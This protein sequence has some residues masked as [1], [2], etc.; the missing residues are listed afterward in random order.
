[1]VSTPVGSAPAEYS[2]TIPTTI[3]RR[4]PPDP[5]RG[6][7]ET[8]Y[9]PRPR[10]LVYAA[11]PKLPPEGIGD[12]VGV[13]RGVTERRGNHP[14]M[15]GTRESRSHE[16]KNP[17]AE[18]GISEVWARNFWSTPRPRTPLS[19]I[20]RTCWACPNRRLSTPKALRFPRP[21]DSRSCPVGPR[22]P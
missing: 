5:S 7:W 16:A 15:V 4:A 3:P 10:A 6:P 19:E 21:T 18:H 14:T 1:M 9:F 13:V 17:G 11:T 2:L 12:M 8:G 20:S 22:S